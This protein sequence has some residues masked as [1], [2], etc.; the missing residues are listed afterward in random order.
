MIIL[1]LLLP[2]DTL[3]RDNLLGDDQDMVLEMTYNMNSLT[4][5][6]EVQQTTIKKSHEL[7]P[8]V[9]GQEK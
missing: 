3:E 8:M 2:T 9:L 4:N 1:L 5:E 6:V 7:V